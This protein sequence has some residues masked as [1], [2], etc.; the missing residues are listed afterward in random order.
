MAWNQRGRGKTIWK[1]LVKVTL[2]MFPI[3]IRQVN[4]TIPEQKSRL[5]HDWSYAFRT[6]FFFFFF[7]SY[8]S[9]TWGLINIKML[10]QQYKNLY[11]AK[12]EFPLRRK[13]I[14]SRLISL[15]PQWTISCH[16]TAFLYWISP[17]LHL[18]NTN[19]E[20]WH[21]LQNILL[22]MTCWK[23]NQ[24]V[25]RHLAACQLPQLVKCGS[26]VFPGIYKD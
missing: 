1:L 16:V 20:S 2:E 23:R 8:L 13:T 22:G 26:S 6:R 12:A 25:S 7:F 5:K 21:L 24:N 17:G 19:T 11:L 3:K 15:Y 9:Y 18:L 4:S 14:S 10:S